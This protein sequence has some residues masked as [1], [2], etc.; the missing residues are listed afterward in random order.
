MAA[1]QPVAYMRNGVSPIVRLRFANGAQ[2][3]CTLNHRIW[4]LNRGYVRA[5]ELTERDQVMVNDSPT[6]ATDASWELPVKVAMAAKSFSRGGTVSFQ[7]AS[8]A[9]ERGACRA[10]RSL[11]R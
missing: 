2:L 9:M 1:T 6:P 7:G 3:R 4:T 10:H 5:E 11:G 8:R